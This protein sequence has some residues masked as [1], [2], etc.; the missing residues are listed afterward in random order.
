MTV[1]SVKRGITSIKTLRRQGRNDLALEEV[2]R[3]LEASPNAA[4]LLVMR[5][6]LIQL[7]DDEDGK[8]TLDDAK[9]ALKLAVELD[10][11]S[12]NAL[13]ELGYYLYAVQDDTKA[14]A[15]Y[16][17]KAIDLSRELLGEALLGHA[18]ALQEL[19]RDTEALVHLQEAEQVVPHDSRSEGFSGRLD[20]FRQEL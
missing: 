7:Q 11:R 14:G 15:K 20:S 16:F 4:H 8:P 3:L 17:Q 18:K 13:I 9:K 1:A 10:D 19:G 6:Q 5:G 12:P 2:D